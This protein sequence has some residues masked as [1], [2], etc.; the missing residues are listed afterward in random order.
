M[1]LTAS[2]HDAEAVTHHLSLTYLLVIAE[3][4]YDSQENNP[5]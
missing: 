1:C 2:K 4:E 5:L 3:T